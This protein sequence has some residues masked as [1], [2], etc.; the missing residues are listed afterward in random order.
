MTAPVAEVRVPFVDLRGRFAEEK[1][2]LIE[3]FERVVSRAQLIGG[4]DVDGFETA[5]ARYIGVDHVVGVGSGTDAL[6]M[7][8]WAHGVGKGDEV[9]TTPVSFIATTGAIVHLGATPVYVDVGPDQNIDPGAIEAAVTP[10]T[11]AIVPVHWAGRVAD[12][13]AINAIAARHDLVVIEDA[14]QAMGAARGGKMAGSFG[15]AAAFSAH[16]LK[17]LSALGD[18]GFVAT[19]DADIALRIRR[20]GAHGL[21]SRDECA[22]YG[23]NS[24]LDALHAAVLELRL[25]RLDAVIGARRRNSELYRALVRCGSIELPGEPAGERSAWSLFNVMADRRD[26]L[27]A[28]LRGRG[29]ESLV[30]YGTPLHLHPAAARFGYSRGDLPVAELQC[31]RVLSLPHHQLLSDAQ[32]AATADAINDFYAA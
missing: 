18:A 6:T 13:D 32:I 28:H 4:P 15:A 24:R 30:Y 11:R 29:I 31:A 23:M 16:P 25:S 7:A 17:P 9:I 2:E 5:A 14:A 27:R 21:V 22:D 8:L 1:D 12:M 19:S 10:R 3:C 20:F 26:E